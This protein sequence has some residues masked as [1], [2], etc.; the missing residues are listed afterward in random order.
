MAASKLRSYICT[1]VVRGIVCAATFAVL[2]SRVFPGNCSPPK[3]PGSDYVDPA[4]CTGCHQKISN[5]YHMTGM[6]RSVYRPSLSNEIE[7]YT[8]HN[9]VYNKRSDLHY[10]MLQRDGKFFQRRYQIGFDGKEIN[11]VEVQVDYVIGS[12][13]QARTYLH[14]NAEGK[15]LEL[16]VSWYVENSGYWAMSPGYDRPDQQD[17]HGETSYECIFCHN[18]YPVP[19][20]NPAVKDSFGQ[21]LPEGIDCQRCH[22]PGRTHVQVAARGNSTPASVRQAIVNPARLSRDRQLEVCMEC[23]LATTGS[24]GANE[25]RRYN[26]EVFSYKPGEPLG[27]YKLYFDQKSRSEDGGG[28]EIADAAYRLRKSACFRESQM[29]C[30]SCHDPHRQLHGEEAVSHYTTVCQSCHQSVVHT[31]LLPPGENCISCHMPRRRGEDAVH[32]VLTDHFIQRYKPNSDLVA[33][34]E[35]LTERPKSAGAISLYYP[36]QLPD[37]PE[38]ELYLAVAQADNGADLEAG[39]SRLRSA[40]VKYSPSQAE[41]YFELGRAEAKAGHNREAIHW[42]DEALRRKVNFRPAIEQLVICLFAAGEIARATEVLKQAVTIPPPDAVLLTNLGNAYARQGMLGLAQKALE[43]ACEINPDMAEAQNL[44]GLVTMRQGDRVGAE[45][46]FRNTLRSQPGMG[47]AHSNLAKLLLGTDNYAEAEYHFQ[48]AIEISP[49]SADAHHNYGLLLMMMQSYDHA[50]TELRESARLYPKEAQFHSDLAA[51]YILAN[52][53]QTSDA[54]EEYKR[55]IQLNPDLP[56]AHLG[57]GLLLISEGSAEEAR[58]HLEKA[59][60]SPDPEIEQA[61]DK[62]LDQLTR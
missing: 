37:T 56:A 3:L 41:F 50:V 31:S 16:P 45:K 25:I 43:R 47:E 32:I 14:R 20:Q 22:G 57:L 28:F 58:T 13:D 23:H 40:I 46:Y 42:L 53:G 11:V 60:R 55:A 49:G 33:P 24:Q 29:T 27:D 62:A 15:L 12:G 38:N 35:E 54:A 30:L 51:A 7:D 44:L 52:R 21:H 36:S 39:I 5:A 4:I 17:F 61:A 59:R 6:G 2:L 1:K 9:E 48:K 10:T 34:R 18:A 19:G 26:R 8:T